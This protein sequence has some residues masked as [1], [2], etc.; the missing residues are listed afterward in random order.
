MS[1]SPVAKKNLS[2]WVRLKRKRKPEQKLIDA[3]L[4]PSDRHTQGFDAAFKSSLSR[5]MD[6][7][8]PSFMGILQSD[9]WTLLLGSFGGYLIYFN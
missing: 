1:I 9:W 4:V 2:S 7:C 8:E 3:S 6:Q 5:L